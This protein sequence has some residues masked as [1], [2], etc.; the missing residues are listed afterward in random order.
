MKQINQF[1]NE[2][3]VKKKLDKPIDSEDHYKYFPET[4]EELHD[5]VKQLIEKRGNE[6]NFN[7]IDTSEIKSQKKERNIPGLI[8]KGVLLFILGYI[9]YL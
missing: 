6:G 9:I 5:L 1:I 3:I 2:Y 7:D 4:K 8:I